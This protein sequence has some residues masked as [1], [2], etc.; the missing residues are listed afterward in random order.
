MKMILKSTASELDYMGFNEKGH[1]TRIN[2][3]GEGVS[4]MQTVLLA[5]AACSAVDVEIFLKKMRN[6]LIRLEVEV[7]G[8][9]AMDE[10]PKV[11]TALRLHYKLFGEIKES[12]AKKSV[13]MAVEKYCSVTKSLDPSIEISFSYEIINE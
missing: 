10:V 8:D 1:G 4:P 11:F 12:S 13:S 3:N 5:A 9:R 6:T 7:E 2:G